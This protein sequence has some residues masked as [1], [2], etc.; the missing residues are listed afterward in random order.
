[1]SCIAVDIGGTKIA[2]AR[3]G[4]DGTLLGEVTQAPTPAARGPLAVI[5][6]AARLIAGVRD[7]SDARVAVSSAGVVEVSTGR[8]AFATASIPGWAGTDVRSELH[9]RCQLPVTVIGD[10]HAFGLGEALFGFGRD[11]PVVLTLAIGTGVGGSFVI[12]GRPQFGRR[13][14]SGHFG[15]MTVPQAIEVA[16]PCGSSGHAEAVGGGA[17]ILGTYRR[18]GGSSE[19]STTAELAHRVNDEQ[20]RLALC[21]GGSAVGTLAAGLAASID[22][23]IVVLAGSIARPQGF[24]WDA[25]VA[26]YRDSCHPAV[27]D[28]PIR[29]SGQ[30]PAMALRGAAHYALQGE[31]A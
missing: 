10:G 31:L 5:D 15:H 27:A 19:V 17:G 20:A 2:A 4:V 3:V 29:V 23:D 6:A 25:L 14:V 8:I 24:W 21:L 22:P 7:E 12:D 13:G 16:C 9:R 30:G 28:T 18:L 26:A 1:M 11:L